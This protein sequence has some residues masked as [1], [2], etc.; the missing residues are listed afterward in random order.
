MAV[1]RLLKAYGSNVPG[2]T[3]GHADD[4][5]SELVRRGVAVYVTAA[6]VQSV[7]KVLEPSPMFEAVVE[8]DEEAGKLKAK[9]RKG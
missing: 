5:A 1:V 9:K 7:E 4:V 2:E 6:P 8:A 3:C